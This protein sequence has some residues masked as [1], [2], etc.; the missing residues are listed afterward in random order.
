MNSL[1]EL[2]VELEQIILF[3]AVI[4]LLDIEGDPSDIDDDGGHG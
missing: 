2:A 3:V 4:H 1:D